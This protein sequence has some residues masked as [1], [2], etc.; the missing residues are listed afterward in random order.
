[1]KIL[2]N[3]QIFQQ[4]YGGASRYIVELANNIALNK[5]KDATVKIISPFFKTEY[6]SSN[7]QNFFSVV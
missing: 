4:K 7:N 3:H 5:D 6:L 2:Y 1:M